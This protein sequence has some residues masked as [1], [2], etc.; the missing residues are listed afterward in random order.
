MSINTEKILT[1]G[2]QCKTR[3]G[4]EGAGQ[5]EGPRVQHWRVP[6]AQSCE[7]CGSCRGVK[8][9]EPSSDRAL[10]APAGAALAAGGASTPLRLQ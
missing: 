5:D 9:G 2:V 1:W 6:V 10:P 7:G 4:A 8:C 3:G